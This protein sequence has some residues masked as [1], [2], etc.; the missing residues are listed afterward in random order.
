MTATTWS[1]AEADPDGTESESE[2]FSGKFVAFTA[3]T[4]N[5][6]EPEEAEYHSADDPPPPTIEEE[7]A[8][9]CAKWE[10]LLKA[11]RTLNGQVQVLEDAQNLL[12]QQITDMDDK[13]TAKDKAIQE[14]IAR[15]EQLA[16]ENSDLKDQIRMMKSTNTLD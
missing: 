14:V 13:I 5:E 15:E 6:T 8:K 9:L 7:H 16:R 2:E 10:I 1:D 3:A 4:G 12:K 11:N